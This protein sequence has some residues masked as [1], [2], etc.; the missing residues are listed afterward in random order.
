MSK[1][2]FAA[3]LLAVSAFAQTAKTFDARLSVHTILR[4]DLFAGFMAND[5]DRLLK[6]EKNLEILFAERPDDKAPLTAWRGLIEMQRAAR[7]LE[8]KRMGDFETEYKKALDDFAEARRLAPNDGGVIA[9]IGGTYMYFGDKL[10]EKQRAAAWDTAYQSFNGLWKFQ[11]A[12]VD[13]LPLHLKGELLAG[14]AQSANRVGKTQ[15]STEYLQKIVTTMPGS[16]YATVAKKWLDNPTLA[17]KSSMGCMTCHDAGR[18]EARKT[19]L[20]K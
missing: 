7:A 18:L 13:Q 11:G 12:M 3:C 17:S 16:P 20:A 10:P 8:A 9:I 6:G 5:N 14:M 4:E 15:E 2:G 19:A 1:L